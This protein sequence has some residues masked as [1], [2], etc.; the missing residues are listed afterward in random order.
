[1]S[2]IETIAEG[3]TLYLGDCREIL[4]TLQVGAVVTDPPYGIA[5]KGDS[6]RFSGGNTRRGRGST[7]GQIK[8]DEAPFDPRPFLV[9]NHQVVFGANNFPQHLQPGSFLIWAKRR[10]AAYGTFLSDGEV[11]WLSKGRGIYMLE[12]TF[13]GSA[14]AMEYSADAYTK[15]AHPFQKPIE[16]M[17]WCIGFVPDTSICDPFMGSGTT[18][19]AAVQL[20]RSFIGIEIDQKYFDVACKRVAEATRQQDM[21]VEAPKLATEQLDM[22]GTKQR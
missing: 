17:K 2:R 20:G 21:F 9:G 4:P 14:A 13:A 3:V 6:S 8:G 15:S 5:H 12:H 11:A 22:L 7:H 18:G 1:M 16:V 19:V 10:P